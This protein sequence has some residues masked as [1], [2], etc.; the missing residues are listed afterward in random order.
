MTRARLAADA[1]A[2]EVSSIHSGGTHCS[3][4]QNGS[5]Y[6]NVVPSQ[7]SEPLTRNLVHT[8]DSIRQTQSF[9]H[10]N[11]MHHKYQQHPH[12]AQQQR[13]YQYPSDPRHPSP[14]FGATAPSQFVYATMQS[15]RQISPN[16]ETGSAASTL[17]SEYQGSD[18][19][20]L[21]SSGGGRNM[22]FLSPMSW[23]GGEGSSMAGFN[24][25]RCHSAEASPLRPTGGYVNVPICADANRRR[26]MTTSPLTKMDRVNEDKPFWFSAGDKERL[27]IPQLSQLHAT[28]SV[29]SAFSDI[30]SQSTNVASSAFQPI[31]KAAQSGLPFSHNR[32]VFSASDR[33]M[34]MESHGHGDLPS[35]MAEAVLN[36]LTGIP[37]NIG[38]IGGDVIVPSPFRPSKNQNDVVR[39]SPFHALNENLILSASG[40]GSVSLFSS[41]ESNRV[42]LGT[43]SWGS[44]R[45]DE[46]HS[47]NNMILSDDFSA[48]L[49]IGEPPSLA[50][51]RGR[52]NTEPPHISSHQIDNTGFCGQHEKK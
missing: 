30:S 36:S 47:N 13:Q 5:M 50:P 42:I 27:A 1:E 11:S 46:A 40:S 28:H 19:A 26:C 21:S 38:V 22:P 51:L 34:S 24:R 45:D 6:A 52:A 33:M 20:M 32:P 2:A 39:E 37:P 29:P 31:G 9:T 18:G 14:V 25:S 4:S 41:G 16:W 8:N 35:S 48:L 43:H 23:A 44:G 3:S 15:P 7:S 17:A 10:V 12:H 49:N